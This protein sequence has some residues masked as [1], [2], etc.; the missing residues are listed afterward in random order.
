LIK[1]VLDYGKPI[2]VASDVNPLPKS[3]EK[4]ASTLGSKVYYPEN[5]LTNKDKFKIVEDFEEDIQ[6]SHQKDALA[7]AL[8]AFRN[9]HKLILKID[10]TLTKL[11]RKDIFD[12]VVR[13]VIT[14]KTEN[15]INIIKKI[16]TKKK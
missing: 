8:K 3:V 6:N 11:H 2:I 10:E 4:I 16:L 14:K 12:E 5:S 7:A 1:Y 13:A 9:Y 15:I